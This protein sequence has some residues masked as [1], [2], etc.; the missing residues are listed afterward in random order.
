MAR[1]CGAISF[2]S[3]LLFSFCRVSLS[4]SRLS[5]SKKPPPPLLFFF[6]TFSYKGTMGVVKRPTVVVVLRRPVQKKKIAKNQDND[7]F[8]LV[9]KSVCVSSTNPLVFGLR[10][11]KFHRDEKNHTHTR[12]TTPKKNVFRSFLLCW[13]QSRRQDERPRLFLLEKSLL[14]ASL[15]G[16][17]TMVTV[18]SRCFFIRKSLFASARARFRALVTSISI[19]LSNRANVIVVDERFRV[20]KPNDW[21]SHLASFR[22]IDVRGNISELFEGGQRYGDAPYLSLQKEKA[23]ERFSQTAFG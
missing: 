6:L 23:V 15:R 8:G 4:L 19:D 3:S 16:K 21:M 7:F 2:L 17:K 11:E 10:A 22:A 18:R 20:S 14:G 13:H 1:F 5:W 9:F 12:V